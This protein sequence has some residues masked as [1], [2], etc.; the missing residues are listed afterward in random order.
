MAIESL[1]D[2]REISFSYT[3]WVFCD[4]SCTHTGAGAVELI[5]QGRSINYVLLAHRSTN[6]H[7]IL[8]IL[9]SSFFHFFL[10]PFTSG[11]TCL[12]Y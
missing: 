4:V 2:D 1:R 8:F 6:I 10:L 7:L 11:E 9:G 3:V 5:F 12:P